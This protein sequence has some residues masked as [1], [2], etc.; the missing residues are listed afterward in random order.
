MALISLRTCRRT[1]PPD[2]H[3]NP[4]IIRLIRRARGFTLLEMVIV[5]GIIAM[6]LGGAIFAMR[7]IG[8]R[9]RLPQVEADFNSF[10]SLLAIYKLNDGT[11]SND[12]ARSQGLGGKP[13]ATPVPRRWVQV[14]SKMPK[15][16]W[17]N[18][19]HLPFPGQEDAP[20]SFEIISQGAGRLGKH[21][22]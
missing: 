9:P 5:L 6:I 7:G 1:H 21:R 20:T 11:L 10:Q 2:I 13:T 16:P 4:S 17:E 12:P 18:R 19:L 8:T 15:D 3:E 22:R 14:M